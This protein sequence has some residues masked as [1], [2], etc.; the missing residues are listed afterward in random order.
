MNTVKTGRF[1]SLIL[2]HKP[3]EIGLKLDSEGWANVAELLKKGNMD[4]ATLEEIVATNNKKRFKFND[5]KTKI[6]AS[7]G[8]SVRVD[9]KLEPQIP[10]DNLFHGTATHFLS[11]IYEKG[12][13]AGSRQ[14]VHLSSD[15]DTAI[16]VGQRHGKPI[17]LNVNAKVMSDDGIKFYLSDNGVWLTDHVPIKYLTVLGR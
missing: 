1:L 7:Q 4:M 16:N 2:R 13:V 11:S 12:L 9:L 10:P 17:V 15:K 8:H 14:Q 5:D 6:R 3:E